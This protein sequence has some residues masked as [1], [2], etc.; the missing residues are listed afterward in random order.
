MEP[1]NRARVPPHEDT[2]Y[3]GQYAPQRGREQEKGLPNRGP[4]KT[5]YYQLG[6]LD[7]VNRYWSR[8]VKFD[9]SMGRVMTTPQKQPT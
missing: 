7:L 2:T 6:Q 8:V 3:R 5:R 4:E 9:S 1:Q